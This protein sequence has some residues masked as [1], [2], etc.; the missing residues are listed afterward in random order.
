MSISRSLISAP[1]LRRGPRL[2]PH[3]IALA[4]FS[5][6]AVVLTWPMVTGFS[7]AVG[8]ARAVL[9]YL[10]SSPE[11]AI[12]HTWNVWWVHQALTTGQ[13]PYW[14]DMLFY[15][16]G[17]QMYVQILGL[18]NVLLTMPVTHLFGPVAG[19]NTGILIAMAASGY[20][21][22]LLARLFTPRLSIALICGL[23]LTASPFHML[24]M[25]IHQHNLIS[26]HWLTLYLIALIYL[27]RAP[28]WQTIAA[29]IVTALLALFSDW[30]WFLIALI[31]TPAW[32][33]AALARST[34][35]ARLLRAFLS[36]A[37]GISLGLLPMLTGIAL[38]ADRLPDV[39]S[40]GP[41]WFDYIKGFSADA[42]GLFGPN[43]LHPIWG[44][45]LWSLARPAQARYAIDGW[46]V[47]AGWV[48]LA[49]AAIGLPEL[50]R[51]QRPL[52]VMGAAA[53]IFSLGPELR[54]AGYQTGIPMPYAL[55]QNLPLLQ[56]ARRPALFTAVVLLVAV[57]AAALG[58][59]RLVERA[60]ASRRSLVIGGVALL[61]A[62]DLAPPST[63]QR[64][65][66]P[67]EPPA[68]MREIA[69][70]PGA[71]ADLPFTWT[72]DGRSLLNQIGHGQPIIGGY[73][74]R[75]PSYPS[76]NQVPLL[77]NIAR[78]RNSQD[79]VPLDTDA[80]R[81][82]QC[83]Y[84]LRHVLLYL[85]EVRPEQQEAIAD[86]TA[87][88]A[89]A[90]VTPTQA[91]DYLW[92]ELPLVAPPCAPF[93]SLG[94]GWDKLEHNAENSWRWMADQS[95]VTLV[96]PGREA[97]RVRLDMRLTAFEEP[98]QIDLLVEDTPY[99][100]W[101]VAAN[102]TRSYT[103]MLTLKPGANEL[104]LRAPASPDPTSPRMLSIWADAIQVRPLGG[105]GG[106][107]P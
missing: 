53:W 22:F 30:Y 80:L 46:Y 43:L 91:G 40:R 60:P 8:S 88:L 51:R 77:G 66:M 31:C 106:G 23:L 10:Y 69:A 107:T 97:L 4:V 49:C 95:I 5:C 55:I 44:E 70:R 61:A 102:Q 34:Q 38:S 47:A 84:P 94:K 103:V 64:Q 11:D 29:T 83:A 78:M 12:Q 105:A 48:L 86:I 90:P 1:I 25:Q 52:V 2:W 89:G 3:L 42:L 74:A 72:E 20:A 81:A 85:P 98:R 14:T 92:Y 17:V 7:T 37:A 24:K 58:I 50:W 71:V 54:V 67:L 27:E 59:Q 56:I 62:I 79:I 99:F 15:P 32:A 6:A 68:L 82:M 73:L 104:R 16:D 33:A 100:S 76:L 101:A 63:A 19:F 87:T 96:N 18:L 39:A 26:M 57:A 75:M 35:P 41:L 28:S 65:L 45:R 13:N 93:A 36:I 9:G 21:G